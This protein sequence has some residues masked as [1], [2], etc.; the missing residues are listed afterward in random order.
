MTDKKVAEPE[1]PQSDQDRLFEAVRHL[2]KGGTLDIQ[3]IDDLLNFIK[4]EKPAPAAG[5]RSTAPAT[6]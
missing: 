3:T 5:S 1:K 4:P 6:K 2:R